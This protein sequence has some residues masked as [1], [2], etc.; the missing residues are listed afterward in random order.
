MEK[1]FE[2]ALQF[3]FKPGGRWNMYNDET[4]GYAF[5]SLEDAKK[6]LE[7]EVNH[8]IEMNRILKDA[9]GSTAFF[10][11]HAVEYWRIV[12]REVG[13]WKEVKNETR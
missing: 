3:R 13:L 9:G 7:Y 5:P 1:H 8:A 11:W 6:T 12:S 4:H 10:G 2:Y